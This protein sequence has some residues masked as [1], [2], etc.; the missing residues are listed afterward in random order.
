MAMRALSCL[1][2]VA[3]SCAH[4][5][6]PRP[7]AATANP[8]VLPSDAELET[9]SDCVRRTVELRRRLIRPGTTNEPWAAKLGAE[10]IF[11]LA[12]VRLDWDATV[13][14][15][16][17]FVDPLDDAKREASLREVG[18]TNISSYVGRTADISAPLSRLACLAD[19]DFVQRIDVPMVMH[20]ESAR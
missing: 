12:D 16:V 9:A 17:L 3:A 20:L 4:A 7:V 18:V 11:K 1:V 2:V 15:Y 14:L 13:I 5:A 10:T 6:Q 8:R 19:L